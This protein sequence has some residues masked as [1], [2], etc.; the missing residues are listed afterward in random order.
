[1]EKETPDIKLPKLTKEELRDRIADG[2]GLCYHP[3]SNKLAILC[4]LLLYTNLNTQWKEDVI[5]AIQGVYPEY[6]EAN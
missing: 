1:M 4:D 5:T 2:V 3:H 6:F